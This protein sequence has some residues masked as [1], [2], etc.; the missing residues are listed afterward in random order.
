MIIN[1]KFIFLLF[2]RYFEGFY[3]HIRDRIYYQSLANL[4]AVTFS[5]VVSKPRRYPESIQQVKQLI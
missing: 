5:Q 1:L 2:F 4:H 3:H